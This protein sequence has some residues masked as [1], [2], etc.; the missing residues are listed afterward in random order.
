MYKSV[1]FVKKKL[2]PTPI[3]LGRLDKSDCEIYHFVIEMA[4]RLF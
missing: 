1:Y 4:F 2:K 3:I